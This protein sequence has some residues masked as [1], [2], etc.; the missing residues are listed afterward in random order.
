MSTGKWQTTGIP[1]AQHEIC[2]LRKEITIY[3]TS[4][5][6]YPWENE[7]LVTYILGNCVLCGFPANLY[8]AQDRSTLSNYTSLVFPDEM[9][10]QQLLNWYF[11][12]NSIFSNPSEREDECGK[13]M[14]YITALRDCEPTSPLPF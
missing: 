11:G 13:L 7:V 9:E 1:E 5:Q 8:L 6:M 12:G 14:D 4:L 10:Q 3:D 2:R